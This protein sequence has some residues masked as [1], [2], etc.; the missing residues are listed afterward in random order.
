MSISSEEVQFFEL[1][2]LEH[3]LTYIFLATLIDVESNEYCR[4]S[5]A[6]SSAQRVEKNSRSLFSARFTF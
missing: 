5:E 4:N 2:I 3:K 1:L 6:A